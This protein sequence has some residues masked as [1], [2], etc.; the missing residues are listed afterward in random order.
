M[1]RGNEKDA[2][3]GDRKVAYFEK[4]LEV[5]VQGSIHRWT[6]LRIVSDDLLLSRKK[7]KHGKQIVETRWYPKEWCKRVG[8]REWYRRNHGEPEIQIPR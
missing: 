3:S 1:R 7:H 6:I 4:G 5:E 2:T 8:E